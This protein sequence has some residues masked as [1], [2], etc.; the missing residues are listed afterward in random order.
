MERL[1][2]PDGYKK[3]GKAKK[4]KKVTAKTKAKARKTPKKRA[5]RRSLKERP[6]ATGPMPT[7]GMGSVVF[8]ATQAPS[9]FRAIGPQQEFGNIPDV[10]KGLKQGQEN[11]MKELDRRKAQE[12]AD[13]VFAERVF[14]EQERKRSPSPV[15]IRSGRS[16]PVVNYDFST[17]RPLSGL[18]PNTLN[19][20]ERQRS[21]TP[22]MIVPAPGSFRA[23]I[24]AI[25]PSYEGSLSSKEAMSAEPYR[26]A[27]ESLPIQEPASGEQ[28]VPS[29][30]S[31]TMASASAFAP[32]GAS[33]PETMAESLSRGRLLIMVP[34]SSPPRYMIKRPVSPAPAPA[35][36]PAPVKRLMTK[37]DV[38][39]RLA[40]LRA[41]KAQE[42]D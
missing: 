34:G 10:L 14:A 36:A 17:A 20:M 33:R 12:E 4:P 2:L 22:D 35:P 42:T 7:T 39:T 9:Y 32:L 28:M 5:P 37:K 31:S 27:D 21:S 3:G 13:K 8:G 11:I 25:S 19:M 38:A 15:T 18:L 1:A 40:E 16:T 6:T 23:P 29:I 24:R 41:K 26:G 30:A